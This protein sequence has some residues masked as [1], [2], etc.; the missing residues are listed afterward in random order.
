LG[1]GRGDDKGVGAEAGWDVAKLVAVE[2]TLDEVVIRLD[3]GKRRG[4][5]MRKRNLLSKGLKRGSFEQILQDE[6][7]LFLWKG[8]RMLPKWLQ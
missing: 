8:V 6:G 2:E 7:L 1:E 5:I 4:L 3:S